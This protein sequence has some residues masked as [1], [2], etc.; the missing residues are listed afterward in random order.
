MGQPLKV[1]WWSW[2]H[3]VH[4]LALKDG[5]QVSCKPG[6]FPHFLIVYGT[7]ANNNA[8]DFSIL[9]CYEWTVQ[10]W[11]R[12]VWPPV[13][14]LST[15]LHHV[16]WWSSTTIIVLLSFSVWAC[17]VMQKRQPLSECFDQ[18]VYIYGMTPENPYIIWKIFWLLNR[19]MSSRIDFSLSKPK[20][21]SFVQWSCYFSIDKKSVI[22][23]HVLIGRLFQYIRTH[24]SLHV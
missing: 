19:S 16:C 11:Y 20:E 7:P 12:L 1:L 5:W 2:Q 23:Y 22:V 18:P 8:P 24:F 13:A 15:W 10:G 14:D 17:C 6:R 9:V 4:A 21:F 3:V